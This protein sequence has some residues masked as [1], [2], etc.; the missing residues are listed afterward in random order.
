MQIN[1]KNSDPA[2]ESREKGKVAGTLGDSMSV[3]KPENDPLRPLAEGFWV[4]P[5][6]VIDHPFP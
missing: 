4:Y 5:I 6:D 1:I 2:E 3:F